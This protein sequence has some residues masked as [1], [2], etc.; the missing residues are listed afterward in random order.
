[1]T[2]GGIVQAILEEL[3]AVRFTDQQTQAQI[4]RALA[5]LAQNRAKDRRTL[6]ISLLGTTTRPVGF[7]YVVAAPVWKTAYRLVLAQDDSGKA[8]LQGWGV[9]ENLTGGDWKDVELSLISGNPV[10]LKQP[11]YTAFY[12][13][14]PEIPVTAAQRIVPRKDDAD[15][16]APPPAPMA[17]APA[18]GAQTRGLMQD[19]CGQADLGFCR[20]G[21]RIRWRPKPKCRSKSAAPPSPPR[22]RKRPRRS[23]IASRKSC[24]LR[25]ARP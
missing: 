20:L 19:R 13:E 12:A 3:A 11:L 5:G 4:D 14:R 9:V 18:A 1:M 24:R 16:P 25:P 17:S 23:P 21:R 10:A 15:E 6:A 7:S 22:P 8:R 2:E